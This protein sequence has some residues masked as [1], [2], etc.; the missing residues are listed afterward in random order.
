MGSG[1]S[2]S[3]SGNL[4]GSG[5]SKILSQVAENRGVSTVSRRYKRTKRTNC[6][7]FNQLNEPA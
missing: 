4:G 2:S 5:R 3:S 1:S 7:L 6:C